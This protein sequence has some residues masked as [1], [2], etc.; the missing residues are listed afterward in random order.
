MNDQSPENAYVTSDL[1]CAAALICVGYKI[2]SLERV[3][4]TKVLFCF[5]AGYDIE[6]CSVA[7]WNNE[8]KILARNYHDSMKMLKSRIYNP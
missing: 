8:L 5:P 2:D 4:D 6:A 3:S 7:Y 1:G